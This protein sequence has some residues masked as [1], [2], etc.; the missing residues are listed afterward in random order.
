MLFFPVLPLVLLLLLLLLLT[1]SR[2]GR[3]NATTPRQIST[4][5][6]GRENTACGKVR[7]E[8][9]EGREDEAGAL[10][11]LLLPGNAEEEEKEEE[12]EEEGMGAW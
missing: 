11:A 12:E 7:G 2:A 4:A 9:D 3:A 10:P 5:A 1:A 8:D 6:S